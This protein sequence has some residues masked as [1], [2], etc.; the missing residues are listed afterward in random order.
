MYIG[1]SATFAFAFS[2]NSIFI[3]SF[4]PLV[5]ILPS[6]QCAVNYWNCVR[7]AS[8]YMVVFHESYN[9][10]PCHWESRHNMYRHDER[11]NYKRSIFF[12]ISSQLASY[13]ICAAITM[14]YY[15]ARLYIVTSMEI[16]SSGAVSMSDIYIDEVNVEVYMALGIIIT[17]FLILFFV[18]KSK[19]ESYNVMLA[20]FLAIKNNEVQTAIGKCW[21]NGRSIMN[22][23]KK[24]KEDTKLDEYLKVIAKYL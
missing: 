14:I 22:A 17:V 10:C 13:Y 2:D 3:C 21:Q 9:D 5:F 7:K 1:V 23:D 19:G 15:F 11:E 18:F 16:R 6:Y 8:A 4:L 12:N 24:Y 20:D